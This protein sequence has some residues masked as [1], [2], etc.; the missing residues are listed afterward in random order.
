MKHL[1]KVLMIAI[2]II[3]F[4]S[5]SVD[6]VN[7][8]SDPVI[9]DTFLEKFDGTVWLYT[10]DL[11]TTYLRIINNET[12]PF[13]TWSYYTEDECY[14]YYLY[15]LNVSLGQVTGN[16]GSILHITLAYETYTLEMYLYITNE[17]LYF[18]QTEYRDG[19][20]TTITNEYL[21][22]NEEV[23]DGLILCE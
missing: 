22:Q 5:C 15:D 11:E 21:I 23:L 16:S 12:T 4:N 17:N 2:F 9:T 7:L 14:D 3:S 10:N 8:F 13:E 1:Y 18:Q 20:Y 6:G 19:E